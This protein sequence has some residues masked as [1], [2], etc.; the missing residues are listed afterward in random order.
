MLFGLGP[1]FTGGGGGGCVL[2]N[3]LSESATLLP[4]SAIFF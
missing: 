3:F 2:G 4:S 1:L